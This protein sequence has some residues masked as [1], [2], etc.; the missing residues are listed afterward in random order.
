MNNFFF[1]EFSNTK[2]SNKRTTK[3]TQTFNP[4]ARCSSIER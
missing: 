1:T 4:F 2:T 3:K